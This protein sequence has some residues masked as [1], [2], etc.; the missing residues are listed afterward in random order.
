M[1]NGQIREI[2]DIALLR[3]EDNSQGDIRSQSA[4]SHPDSTVDFILTNRLPEACKTAMNQMRDGNTI[5][6]Q[7]FFDLYIIGFFDLYELPQS[8]FDTLLTFYRDAALIKALYF[9]MFAQMRWLLQSTAFMRSS[10]IANE[11]ARLADEKDESL[12]ELIAD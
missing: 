9:R 8:E 2:L 5:P 1:R 11:V 12:A 6:S 7:T 4:R 3:S 10:P